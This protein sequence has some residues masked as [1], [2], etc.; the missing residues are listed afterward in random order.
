MVFSTPPKENKLLQFRHWI[1]RLHLWVVIGRF[2]SLR[3][4]G[5]RSIEKYKRNKVRLMKNAFAF[6]KGKKCNILS[7][8]SDVFFC[9]L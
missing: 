8:D 4:I 5:L 9:K 7:S 6:L 3:A 1:K 2:Q